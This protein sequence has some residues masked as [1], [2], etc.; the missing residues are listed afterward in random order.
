MPFRLKEILLGIA[1]LALTPGFPQKASSFHVDLGLV[2]N[3]K[4]FFRLF[5]GVFEAG[6]GYNRELLGNLHG[7]LSMRMSLISRQGTTNRAVCYK[8]GINLQY[9][10][11]LSER[12]AVVP[13]AGIGYSFVSVSHQ[14]FDYRETRPGWNPSAALRILWKREKKLDYYVFGNLDYI[15]LNEDEDFTQLRYYRE[16][17]ISSFGIG[18]RIKSGGR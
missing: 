8:P 4:G 15:L 2:Q 14:E 10:L 1:L 17:W 7:G 12:I 18:L 9:Y 13:L 11:H 3:H 16:I 6:A 5:G